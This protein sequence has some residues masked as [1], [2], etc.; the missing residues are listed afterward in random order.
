VVVE[1]VEIKLSLFARR[2]SSALETADGAATPIALI[3]STV[4]AELMLL[5]SS[6]RA[7]MVE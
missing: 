3:L 2:R 5:Q 1:S 6:Q 7:K 4:Y